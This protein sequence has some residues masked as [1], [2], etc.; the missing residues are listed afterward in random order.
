VHSI[1]PTTVFNVYLFHVIEAI[2][3]FNLIISRVVDSYSMH[4]LLL[5][6]LYETCRVL[7]IVFVFQV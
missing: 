3:M 7:Y 6:G 4:T 2:D 1:L 5:R